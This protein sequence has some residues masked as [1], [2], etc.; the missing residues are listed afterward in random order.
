MM[1]KTAALLFNLLFISNTCI[2]HTRL[3]GHCLH[4]SKSQSISKRCYPTRDNSVE[5]NIYPKENC[6]LDNLS[7]KDATKTTNKRNDLM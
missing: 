7:N 5:S 2:V 6:E 3:N 4:D 1:T